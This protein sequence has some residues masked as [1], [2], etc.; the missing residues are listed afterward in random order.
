M[1]PTTSAIDTTLIA[2]GPFFREPM[3]QSR[4]A[5]SPRRCA[6]NTS[7]STSITMSGPR[8][9][10]DALHGRPDRA[11]RRQRHAER[12]TNAR[13]PEGPRRDAHRN[14]PERGPG[15]GGSL[16]HATRPLVLPAARV[17]PSAP[18]RGKCSFASYTT[19]YA[20]GWAAQ[21]DWGSWGAEYCTARILHFASHH[22]L[23]PG[24]DIGQVTG[25]AAQ[26]TR[27]D[28]ERFGDHF[29]TVGNSASPS[30]SS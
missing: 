13:S 3:S 26:L 9:V 29:L 30:P 11:P 14:L 10:P 4:A 19:L 16:Q 27:C 20:K 24:G 23:H 25:N 7:E 21:A 17:P 22:P 2:T 15:A 1:P 6:I 5:P 18:R 28:T 12:R 8:F